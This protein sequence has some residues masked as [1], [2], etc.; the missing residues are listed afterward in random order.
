[1]TRTIPCQKRLF[2]IPDDIHYLN[3]AYIS[4]LM[5]P[6]LEAAGEGLRH[7]AQPW[8][9]SPARFFEPVERAR[10]LFAGLIGASADDVAIVP[11]ASYGIAT[12]AENL[13]VPAGSKIVVLEEQ[14]PSNV[15]AWRE[16]ARRREATL[17]T[18]PRPDDADW[19]RAVLELLDQDL[20][21][22]ALPHNHWTDGGLLDLAAIG[23]R[24]RALGG[25]L[26][27]DASQSA[28]ALPVDVAVVQPD[29]LTTCGYKWMLC[30]Y[31]VSFLYVAPR[32]Q[33][34]RGLEENPMNRQ[35]AIDFPRMAVLRDEYA[36][37]ARRFDAGER[38]HFTL[39]PAAIAVLEQLNAWGPQSIQATLKQMTAAVA[40]EAGALG[41]TSLP[42]ERRAGHFLGLR[43]PE[44]RFPKG[45]PAGLSEALA[46]AG[47]HVSL[48]GT[49]L[50]VT[51]HLWNDWR[52]LEAL[53]DVLKKTL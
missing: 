8:R 34:G 9:I 40:S 53:I 17:E 10:V 22:A 19:T 45:P 44:H 50:R 29:F 6:A 43:F 13:P 26:V 23:E 12:A 4:P 14:Y 7:E 42:P 51:P 5:R 31:G 11:A 41:L 3:C 15:Y 18:V 52:D 39:M 25:A 37:G 16:L 24:V 28:G 38:A 49:S 2:D 20:A 46:E 35:G 47:V 1:M 30:P 36:I 21:V 27:I 33:E 32:W 48:R